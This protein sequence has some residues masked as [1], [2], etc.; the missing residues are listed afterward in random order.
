MI[1]VNLPRRFARSVPEPRSDAHRSSVAYYS[2]SETVLDEIHD[3]EAGTSWGTGA[4]SAPTLLA[5]PFGR[6]RQ[7]PHC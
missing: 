6:S 5:H 4:A 3:F 7:C 2:D 1:T